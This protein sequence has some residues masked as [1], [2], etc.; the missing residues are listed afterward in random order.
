MLRGCFCFAVT[1]I[2]CIAKIPPKVHQPQPKH[3]VNGLMCPSFLYKSETASLRSLTSPLRLST[4]QGRPRECSLQKNVTD[5]P[6]PSVL[7]FWEV[8][9]F[10]APALS[11]QVQEK[12][13][14]ESE[15]PQGRPWNQGSGRRFLF[16]LPSLR[17]PSPCSVLGFLPPRDTLTLPHNRKKAKGKTREPNQ[18]PM[19]GRRGVNFFQPSSRRQP[20]FSP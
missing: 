17:R 15:I 7:P 10:I 20:E 13:H 3:E 2:G 8:S 5:V 9:I 1:G 6:F 11:G 12:R 19:T 4:V 18:K 16:C 14:S